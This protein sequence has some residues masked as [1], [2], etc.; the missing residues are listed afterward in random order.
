MKHKLIT[1][2]GTTASGKS[3]LAIKLARRFDAEIISAD[4]RQIYKGLDLGTGKVTNE[5]QALA[6]HHLI[7]ILDPNT[8]YSAAEFQQDA[9]RVIDDMI[10]R[11]KLPVLCGGTGL[12]S[13]AVVEGYDFSDAPP[14]LELR[15]TLS[16]KTRDELLAMLADHGVVDVDPQ[17]SS[18]HLIRMIEKLVDGRSHKPCN[19]P[20]YDVLQL[21]MTYERP[22]LLERIKARLEAR[23]A[24]GMIDE[25]KGLMQK[26]AT[27]E[28][29]EGLG[30]EYRYTYRYIAG[31][32]DSYD[33][34]FEQL[35]TEIN[36]FSKRQMTWFRKEKNVIWLDMNKDFESQ[37][38]LCVENFLN[39]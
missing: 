26:G 14:S 32:Y 5:E 24:A 12:Y 36:K 29:L 27:P 20:K 9:Y 1:V 22:V 39:S 13:R 35:N 11:G 25:V 38:I 7:D 33:A 30:L 2:I 4:S 23:I 28:F 8:P 6:K 19:K 10:E 37:A 15:D 31:M 3:D 16:T 17:K 18:R 21:G 34:Y